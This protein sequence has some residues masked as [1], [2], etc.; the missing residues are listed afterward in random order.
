MAI[1]MFVTRIEHSFGVIRTFFIYI[2][3]G[4]GGNIFSAL[5]DSNDV[6]AGASTSLYGVIGVII[7]YMIINW[8][9]LNV[10]GPIL[11][12]QLCCTSVMIIAFIFFFSVL[13]TA[14][15]DAFGHL[16]GFLTGLFLASIN[17]TIIL[18]TYEKVIRIIFFSLFIIEYVVCFVVFFTKPQ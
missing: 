7:G 3:S 12:Y 10:V 15:V 13:G 9:G 16:G 1:F 18:N 5:I 4:I 14:N 11:K 17:E 8:N 6:K 2:L